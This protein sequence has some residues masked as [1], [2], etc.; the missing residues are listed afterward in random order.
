MDHIN[1]LQRASILLE[2][3]R[4]ND[5]KSEIEQILST[6]PTNAEALQ[7]LA[8][9][10]LGLEKIEKAKEVVES[11]IQ[12]DPTNYYSLY[13]M[14]FVQYKLAKYKQSL[15]YIDSAITFNPLFVEAYGVKSAAHYALAQFEE[16]LTAANE[17]LAI[18]ADNTLCLNQRAK[19]LLK[20]GRT[21]EN[22]ETAQQALKNDPEDAHTHA[23]MG[24]TQLEL[25]KIEEAQVHFKEALRLEPT[26]EF[27]R[28]GMLQTL[29][30]NSIFYRWWL[31]YVFW[32]Q[33]LSPRSRWIVIIV[34]YLLFRFISSSKSALGSWEMVATLFVYAYFVFAI[35]SWI[36][37]P[38]SNIFLRFHPF[39][40]YV[41]TEEEKQQANNTLALLLVSLMGVA[42]LLGFNAVQWQNIGFYLLCYGIALIVI[43]SA[44][45]SKSTERGI[46]RVKLAGYLFAG[47]AVLVL[48]L[49]FIV[50]NMATQ[51][52]SYSVWGFVGFQFYANSQD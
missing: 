12:Q 5:A 50:P 27:A 45:A 44:V 14:G 37:E 32:M 22:E 28:Y 41:L 42:I 47:V 40:K 1:N 19:A 6:D 46:R 43:V 9:C 38:V 36:I 20:L 21:E 48:L 24:Y 16:A 52:F 17:G 2:Q 29:K 7:I 26:N 34:A 15:K 31:K 8:G 3:R 49:G 10:Y 13:L 23:N 30:A 33:S 35:S 18:Q 39:G 11:A 51:V 4:F 25:G